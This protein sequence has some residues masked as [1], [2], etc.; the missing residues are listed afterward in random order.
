MAPETKRKVLCYPLYAPKDLIRPKGRGLI[1]SFESFLKEIPA[2]L[3]GGKSRE[4]DILDNTSSL[5]SLVLDEKTAI[6]LDIE[7]TGLYSRKE[8]LLRVG[9]D[10]RNDPSKRPL[11]YRVSRVQDL[12]KTRQVFKSKSLKTV[13][14]LGM[15]ESWCWNMFGHGL[16]NVVGDTML[17]ARREDEEQA[18]SLE[19]LAARKFPAEFAGYKL[20]TN[21]A[22]KN[23]QAAWID[24]ALLAT[25]NGLDCRATSRLY[26]DLE[27]TLGPEQMQYHRDYDIPI[28]QAVARMATAGI[29]LSRP[30]L[31]DVQRQCLQ[32]MASTTSRMRSVAGSPGLNPRSHLQIRGVL[33]ALGAST[34]KTTPGGKMATG[35]LPLLKLALKY[36]AE[37]LQTTDVERTMLSLGKTDVREF[38]GALLEYREAEKV[39]STYAVGLGKQTEAGMVY[40]DW[41][42]P[43]TSTWRLSSSAPN[44]QN[45]PVRRKLGREVRKAFVSRWPDGWLV[46]ADLSQ[47][48]LRIL[49]CLSND[50]N[51]VPIL[52]AGGD[53]HGFGA[54][55]IFGKDYTPHQRYVAKTGNFT[56]VYQGGWE[57]IQ[58]T[59]LKE[60][61]LRLSDEEARMVADGIDQAFPDVT[62]YMQN[63][64]ARA[65]AGEDIHAPLGGYITRPGKR[66]GSLSYKMQQEEA[67][68]AAN[69]PIQCAGSIL[70][71]RSLSR[72]YDV[73]NMGDAV[74][75]AVVHDSIL[76]DCRTRDVA[77][78]TAKTV[79]KVMEETCREQPWFVVPGVA[80]AKIG[81]NWNEMTKP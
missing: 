20:D 69:F 43:G 80:E 30:A 31:L 14:N 64:V 53:L 62:I 9:L 13:H 56:R 70:T 50:R 72:L 21:E 6:S 58:E 37:D 59:L 60:A 74:P 66:M 48:E 19:S 41:R 79:V 28:A 12:E 1:D 17:M 23:G 11:S 63:A 25:R 67:R 38:T 8:H 4:V 7:S 57:K 45:I 29:R 3:T 44:L 54:E 2:L 15:E 27:K 24:P 68:S 35:K 5:S 42:W 32:I 75:C 61:G 71:L 18:L 36:E 52:L 73:L 34:G 49:A 81:Q 39:L 46:E 10:F 22:L 65:L 51:M 33:E 76:V 26:E 77:L 78:E 47:I 55:R 40:S 16:V